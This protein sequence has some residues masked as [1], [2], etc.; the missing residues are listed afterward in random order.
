MEMI[1]DG[2]KYDLNPDS[3]KMTKDNTVV[4]KV[5]DIFNSEN[6]E[7][8]DSKS[9]QNRLDEYIL[10]IDTQIGLIENNDMPIVKN[11]IK[12]NKE[13]LTEAV[14]KLDNAYFAIMD[15][16]IFE[17]NS[18]SADM[19][20]SYIHNISFLKD[21][22]WHVE[23]NIEDGNERFQTLKKEVVGYKDILRKLIPK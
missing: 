8:F 13:L 16:T 4:K 17:H 7:R 1:I 5:K 19:F 2:V 21:A 3:N 10:K 22:I 15:S 23:Q 18:T 14:G 9:I 6:M 12:Q 11:E 20:E